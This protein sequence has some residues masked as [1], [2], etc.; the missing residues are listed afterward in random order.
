[1][2]HQSL[3]NETLSTYSR[4]LGSTFLLI[5]LVYKR[6]GKNPSLTGACGFSQDFHLNA[7]PRCLIVPGKTQAARTDTAVPGQAGVIPNLETEKSEAILGF[8]ISP[9]KVLHTT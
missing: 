8:A 5:W 7:V 4:P 6:S 1:M 3:K 2:C 9:R